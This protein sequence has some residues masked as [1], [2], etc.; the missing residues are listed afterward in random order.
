MSHCTFTFLNFKHPFPLPWHLSKRLMC[1]SKCWFCKN[2]QR[3]PRKHFQQRLKHNIHLDFLS[4]L[5]NTE[6]RNNINIAVWKISRI[7]LIWFLNLINILKQ[8]ST[9]VEEYIWLL[10]DVTKPE[11]SI[12]IHLLRDIFSPILPEAFHSVYSFRRATLSPATADMSVPVF[13]LVYWWGG[14]RGGCRFV[15]MV[16]GSLCSWRGAGRTNNPLPSAHSP[17]HQLSIPVAI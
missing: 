17:A 14:C 4:S 6:G 1:I 12:V 10:Y 15:S 3:V 11:P 16:L 9:K 2:H 13:S 5:Y 8:I 7:L